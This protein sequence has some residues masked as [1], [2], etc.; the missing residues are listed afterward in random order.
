MAR[1]YVDTEY[2]HSTRVAIAPGATF[3]AHT[4]SDIGCSPMTPTVHWLW[5]HDCVNESYVEEGW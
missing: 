5:V 3:Q 2:D 4:L 1:A